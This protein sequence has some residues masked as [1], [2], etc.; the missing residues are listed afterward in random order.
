ML[1]QYNEGICAII[2]FPLYI[3][4][5]HM[6]SILVYVTSLKKHVGAGG[7][8]RHQY[9]YLSLHIVTCKKREM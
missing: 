5:V 7:W 6:H 3:I 8:R 1:L 2:P 9:K 4:C